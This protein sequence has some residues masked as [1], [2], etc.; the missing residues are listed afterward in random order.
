[1]FQ[2]YTS[3]LTSTKGVKMQIGAIN[4]TNFK[5]SK[6]I[7]KGYSEDKTALQKS[8]TKTKL[9]S[10]EVSEIVVNFDEAVKKINSN[11]HPATIFATVV[12][13]VGVAKGS[14]KLVPVARRAVVTVGEEVSALGTKAFGKVANLVK[15]GSF[16]TDKA[17]NNIHNFS[18]ANLRVNNQEIAKSEEKLA[19]AAKESG[20][21]KFVEKYTGQ[22]LGEQKAQAVKQTMIKN[23]MYNGAGIFDAATA[24]AIGLGVVDGASDK[25][26]GALDKKDLK[27]L[28]ENTLSALE[29]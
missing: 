18:A 20:F 13:A 15:K 14:S 2:L 17:V 21:I 12:A 16:D 8:L 1:M 24:F 29:G 10:E 4:S 7:N 26:E 28:I 22:I 6:P 9:S 27:N 3:V 19:K 25:A 23:N 5:G 11:V